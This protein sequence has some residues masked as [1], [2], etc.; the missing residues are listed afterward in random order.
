MLKLLQDVLKTFYFYG[1]SHPNGEYLTEETIKNVSLEDVK[2]EYNTYF[3]PA[4]AYLVIIGDV[5]I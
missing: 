4:D 2:R 1:K 3:V 5:R